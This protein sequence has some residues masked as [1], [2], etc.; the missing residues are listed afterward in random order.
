MVLLPGHYNTYC[1]V[2]F[3]GRFWKLQLQPY[4]NKC[5]R[6][7]FCRRPVISFKMLWQSYPMVWIIMALV[8]TVIFM[9][10]VFK[11]T[12]VQTLKRNSQAN[13]IYKK[14]WHAAAIFFLG[15]CLYGV[16]SFRPLKWKDAF[17]L[18][19]NFKS[20]VALNPL[21]NFFTTLQFRKA[22]I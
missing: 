20:Y 4:T 14:R 15:W 17:E 13:I 6:I 19:D 1:L 7:K 8:L 11:K 3:R 18:N 10:R 22:I 21:Q 2:F 16:F 12:H 5:K 9:S